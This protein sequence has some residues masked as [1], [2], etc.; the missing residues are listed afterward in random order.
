VNFQERKSELLLPHI[1]N[2]KCSLGFYCSFKTQ[3][4]VVKQASQQQTSSDK[5]KDSYAHASMVVGIRYEWR[6]GRSKVHVLQ[7][8]RIFT[9]VFVLVEERNSNMLYGTQ[10][11]QRHDGEREWHP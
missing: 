5:A 11:G 3:S 9:I 4:E 6:G 10:A 8:V 7:K 1:A 2:V